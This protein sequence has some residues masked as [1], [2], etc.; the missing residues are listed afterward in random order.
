MIVKNHESL[1][2]NFWKLFIRN[3]RNH[4]LLNSINLIGL[5]MGFVGCLLIVLYVD[6]ELCFDNF[7]SKSNKIF[8][9]EAQTN[10]E[11]WIADLGKETAFQ[12]KST[13]SFPEVEKMIM[14]NQRTRAFVSKGNQRLAEKLA[15]QTSV[16]SVFF[17]LFQFDFIEGDR[18]KALAE[19]N[20]VVLTAS[21]AKRYFGRSQNLL[22]ETLNYDS[23]QLKVTGVLEDLPT[24]T[25]F[26]FNLL[27]T[28]PQAFRQDHFHVQTFIQL[29][30][31]AS[32]DN[33]N[34]K[35][36][37]LDIDYGNEWH[38]LTAVRMFPMTDI[39]L[40]SDT[41]F[42]SAGKGDKLQI[43]IFSILGIFILA[44]AIIN[45]VNMTFAIF[46]NKGKEVGVRKVLGE[47]KSTI[48]LRLANQSI[49]TTLLAIP[50]IG[51]TLFL[52]F[53]KFN[54]FMGVNLQNVLLEKPIYIL[55]TVLTLVFVA[56]LTVIYPML[57]MNKMDVASMIKS[58][59][60]LT[61]SGGVR[62]RNFLTL[63]QFT[64]L[65]TLGISAWFMN[66]Q[67][68][69]LDT[70]DK[71]FD[72][73]NI[74]KINNA[75][76]LG[77]IE[78]YGILKNRL[79]THPQIDGVTF[80]PMMGDGMSPM[81]YK[82]EGSEESY[83]NLLSYGVGI[84]YFDVMNISV[85]QGSFKDKIQASADG[86]VTSLVNESF[87]NRFNWNSEPIGKKILLRP[88][89]EN[90][91]NR[92]V[93]AVFEDFHFF[94]FK[95]KISPQIISLRPDPTFINTNIL[96]RA[97]PNQLKE[98][99]AIV[100]EE[101]NKINTTLPV[102]MNLME[103]RV[104]ELYEKERQ[105][106]TLGVFLSA[107]AIGLSAM[108]IIGFMFYIISFKSKEIA[109]RKVLGANILQ[110]IQLLNKQLFISILIAGIVG[111]V[112]SY[113][114]VSRWLQDYAYAVDI[115]PVVFVTA[116]LLVYLAVFVVTGF[117]TLKST[118]INPAIVL[119]EE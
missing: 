34:Q 91:L 101:W 104:Q 117:Q 46:L 43:T 54:D 118:L 103:E 49:V 72:P 2:S 14:Y 28:D 114:L 50:I 66:Q 95:E 15:Y 99:M 64:L 22:G 67:I 7:H 20:S 37:D 61:Q 58:K 16:G 32:I 3:Y 94:S 105:T 10:S 74:I 80:G 12:I 24:H 5:S 4:G 108:G 56:L 39:H 57:A 40:N 19:P 71:G 41:S 11:T 8:R 69:Y 77:S 119:K 97:K 23:V 82:P 31:N 25:H 1:M 53:P 78:D 6:H 88:G 68:R 109:I 86:E 73:A 27:M 52:L 29:A 65:F 45:Y 60:L 89:T 116:V 85:L 75:W 44:I 79:M 113:F 55:L 87:V 35:I 48:I 21:A 26:D 92:K 111:S 36:L 59:M 62:Y 17:D 93:S 90:E 70:K 13:G 38:T 30:D 107:L 110:I 18:E 100:E 106:G 98:A 63:L 9:M 81:S 115:S 76:D 112:G 102:N 33:L 51:A 96:I 47:K 83:E 42:G 84:D